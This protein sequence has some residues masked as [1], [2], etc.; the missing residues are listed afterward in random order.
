MPRAKRRG[1]LGARHKRYWRAPKG[2]YNARRKT[3]KIAKQAVDK[4]A[5]I[6][7][8]ATGASRKRDFRSLWIVRINAAA[9]EC[10]MSYS[11]FMNGLKRPRSAS[12]ARCWPTSRCMTGRPLPRSRVNPRRRSPAKGLPKTASSR[13]QFQMTQ[14][15]G[16][17]NRSFLFVLQRPVRNDTKLKV[18]LQP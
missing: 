7:L 11:R 13:L 18:N 9:R 5:P 8:P 17:A 2:Y 10:G 3:I 14:Q 15:R 16:K 12:T 6:R 4:A 1:Y